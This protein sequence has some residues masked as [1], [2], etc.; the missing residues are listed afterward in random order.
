M[1]KMNAK[2]KSCVVND[3]DDNNGGYTNKVGKTPCFSVQ[4]SRRTFIMRRI[5][6]SCVLNS[7]ETERYDAEKEHKCLV[8]QH[9]CLRVST[10][11]TML[12]LT[13]AVSLSLG[14]PII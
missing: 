5:G 2:W 4:N 10:N 9:A 1:P 3:D 12:C 8:C 6:F 11:T 14:A 13:R 7:R